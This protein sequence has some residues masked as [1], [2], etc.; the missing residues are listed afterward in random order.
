MSDRS[1]QEAFAGA[2]RPVPRTGVIYV[3]TEA[4]ARG[5]RPGDAGWANLG[6][7]SPEVG[8]LPGAPP[9]VTEMSFH[10]D[11]HR[12]APVSG[13]PELRAAVADLYNDLYRKGSRSR[14]TAENVAI[15]GGGRLA[16]TRVVAALAPVNLGHFLPDYTAYEELLSIFRLFSP[17]AILLDRERGYRFTADDL[18]REVVGRGLSAVLRSN[19]CNPTGEHLRGDD[20][21]GWVRT[22]R[23]LDCALVLDEFYSHY[24]WSDGAAGPV[25]AAACVEDVDR[26]PVIIV[27]G[28][29]KNWRYPGWRVAW[30]VGP[31]RVIEALAS[32]GSF[33][34]GGAPTPLQAATIPLLDAARVRQEA[35]AIR[36]A[37]L[38]KRQRMVDGARD[39][40]LV[41][42]APP[43]GGFYA[44]ASLERLPPPFDDGMTFFRRAL[45]WKV[46]CVPG[47]FFDVNPGKRRPGNRGKRF[48]GHVRLSF[49]PPLEEVETGLKRLKAMVPSL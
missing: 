43:E 45:E 23:E 4:A 46:I 5:Y 28:L 49:G 11:H 13:L 8:P 36:A 16:L 44:W 40:G 22:A 9:R 32:A 48:G 39:I 27:D 10:L 1:L 42:D 31:K 15:S 24:V 29:T 7:G 17:I 18:R 47:E 6:Q 20:L 19:P 25:S 35:A 26:D 21:A 38:Q 12:Y 3:T 37:F 2:F 33:L 34:D 14:Y 30:T 41:V